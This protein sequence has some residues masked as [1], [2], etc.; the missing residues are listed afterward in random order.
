[1]TNSTPIT[2]SVYSLFR[3]LLGLYIMIHFAQLLPYAKELFSN[4]GLFSASLSPLLGYIPNPLE[5]Y[6]S[7]LFIMIVLGLGVL[8]G[9]F[10]LLGSYDRVSSLFLILLLG[11]LYTRN[12][13]I[14]NPSLPVVGWVLLMHMMLPRGNYGALSSKGKMHLWT[15]WFFPK[16]IWFAAWVLLSVAYSYSGYT[17]LMSPSWIDGSAIEIVLSN[18]LARDHLLNNLLLSTPSFVLQILTWTIMIIELLFVLFALWEPTRKMVWMI[19]LLAQIGFLI[20]FDFADLTIPMLLFHLLTFDRNWLKKYHAKEEAI[21]FYDGTCAF[22]NGMVRFAMVED[23]DKKLHYAPLEG[24]VFREKN[25]PSIEDETII[26][27]RENQVL[28]KSDAAIYTLELLGGLWWVLAKIMK[29]IP[30]SFRDFVYDGIGRI[31]YLL[32]GKIDSE[33]CPILPKEYRERMLS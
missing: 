5:S 2:A 4:E 26:I 19:M 27:F 33:G 1:V 17:K 25:V 6:D 11:W 29:V 13:L 10:V 24:E 31:R 18:P 28:Y 23:V 8:A 3:I 7:P 15:E 9:F 30:Q 12:P 22:C 21:L 20:S 14:A 16:Q 32:A